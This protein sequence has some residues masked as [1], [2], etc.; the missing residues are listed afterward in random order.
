MIMPEP[1]DVSEALK[2]LE[3]IIKEEQLHLVKSALQ[4]EGFVGMTVYNVK[5]RGSSGGIT[6][7]WRA[8][9]YTVD[10]LNK[11]LVMLVV[12]AAECDKA[13]QC[14]RHVCAQEGDSGLLIVT[15]V[16]RIILLGIGQN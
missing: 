4:A 2:K 14:I 5:G 6:L 8:G 3:V 7:E 15:P 1:T 10:F 16:D 13:I 12:P 11:V 9:S